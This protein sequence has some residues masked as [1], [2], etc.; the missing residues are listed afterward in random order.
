MR[1]FDAKDIRIDGCDVVN[2]VLM[3]VQLHSVPCSCILIFR[4]KGHRGSTKLN[5]IVNLKCLEKKLLT[6]GNAKV[7]DNPAK[8]DNHDLTL[9]SR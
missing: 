4:K 2:E 9:T 5:I 6:G 1:L 7:E 8:K 3:F